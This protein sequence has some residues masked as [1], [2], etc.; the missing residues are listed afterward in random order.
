[1]EEEIRLTEPMAMSDIEPYIRQAIAVG[2][3]VRV[4]VKGNSMAPF[5]I[6][7]RDTVF[8]EAL[9]SRALRS[10][11]ILLFQRKN[12]RYV[13]HRLYRIENGLLTF[14]GDN[15]SRLEKGVEKEQ[16]IAFVNHCV[17][18]GKDLYCD[19]SALNRFMIC[20]M[21]FRVRFP[22]LTERLVSFAVKVKH[23]G[24]RAT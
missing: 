14:V 11:D 15:Q 6:N 22:K 24:G 7:G 17:R 23:I 12:G 16:V 19:H 9:P 8:F 20:Y 1:M 3:S 5:L 13:M 10:G 2:G 18:G 21:K 4:R